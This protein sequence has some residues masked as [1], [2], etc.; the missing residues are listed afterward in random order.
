[1]S[2]EPLE[3]LAYASY[4][5]NRYQQCS[6]EDALDTDGSGTY[7]WFKSFQA[8]RP[9]LNNHLPPVASNPDILHLGCGNSVRSIDISPGLGYKGH[10]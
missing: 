8:L 6:G 4:W 7:D 3:Q 2:K 10:N 5:D 1:M 9:F